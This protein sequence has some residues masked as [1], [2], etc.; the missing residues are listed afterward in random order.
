MIGFSVAQIRFVE[1]RDEV[2]PSS[3]SSWYL[4][5]SGTWSSTYTEGDLMHDATGGFG[6]HWAMDPR[7]TATNRSGDRV[8]YRACQ[9]V[10]QC[11][12]V[13]CSGRVRPRAKPSELKQQLVTERCPIPECGP[14]T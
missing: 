1:D 2:G 7:K 6:V 9:G 8:L 4:W 3:E 11:S 13:E 12:R 10:L 5:P 14:C